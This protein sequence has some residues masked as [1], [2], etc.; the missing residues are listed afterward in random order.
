MMPALPARLIAQGSL[1]LG[2]SYMDGWWDARS[3]DGLLFRLLDAHIDERVPGV[4]AFLDA[5]RARLFNLQSRS[6]SFKVGER[7][8]D[9]GNDLYSRDARQAPGVQ[10]R[11]LARSAHAGQ[12]PGGKARPGLPQA[13]DCGPACACSTSAAAGARR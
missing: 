1:G 6:R 10:L 2:E 8:Y 9:L 13:A 4:A 5:L 3:L 7:H 12:G 11:L